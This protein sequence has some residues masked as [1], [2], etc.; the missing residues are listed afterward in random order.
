MGAEQSALLACTETGKPEKP[1]RLYNSE[2]FFQLYFDGMP[3][4]QTG[5]V[6]AALLHLIMNMPPSQTFGTISFYY[7]IN[8]LSVT[9]SIK[10]RSGFRV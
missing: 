4:P 1:L 9:I 10:F 6:T 7:I 2:Q 8:L 3:E 5:P